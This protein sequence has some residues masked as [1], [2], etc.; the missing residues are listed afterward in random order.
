MPES[1]VCFAAVRYFYYEDGVLP[2]IDAINHTVVADAIA[3]VASEFS[4]EP[5]DGT[6]AVRLG[7][8]MVEATIQSP[9]Q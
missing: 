8:Q 4:G 1:P 5:L 2:V 9:L 7:L 3:I 6:T